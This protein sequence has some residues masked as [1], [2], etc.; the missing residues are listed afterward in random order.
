M[1]LTVSD[2]CE[3]A[4]S[5]NVENDGAEMTFASPSNPYFY[6]AEQPRASCDVMLPSETAF[7]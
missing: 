4:S 6:H 2:S 3:G 7:H 5:A 1:L